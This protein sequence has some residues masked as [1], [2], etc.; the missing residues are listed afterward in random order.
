MA[1][2][3]R[4]YL[5][6]GGCVVLVGAMFV[7]GLLIQPSHTQDAT[8]GPVATGTGGSAAAAGA[9]AGGGAALDPKVPHVVY[10]ADFKTMPGE[11]WSE[12][13]PK[14]TP[15]GARPYW[16]DFYP[17]NSPA[18]TVG[19]LPPHK[20]VRLTYDMLL[21]KSWDGSSPTYGPSVMD[22]ALG[23]EDGRSL[24]H[25]T[26][27]NMGMYPRVNN[28]QSFP[29][30]YFSRPYPAFTLATEN[31]T[32][33]YMQSFTSQGGHP[34]DDPSSVYHMVMTFPHEAGEIVVKWKTTIRDGSYKGYGFMNMRV[35]TLPELKTWS[36]N[37]YKMFWTDLGRQTVEEA[38]QFYTAKW[39]LIAAGDG[40]VA[41][42]EK[43]LAENIDGVVP[44]PEGDPEADRGPAYQ[45]GIF[46]KTPTLAR[47]QRT[48]DVLEAIHTPAA[49]AF[50]EKI[51]AFEPR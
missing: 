32:L 33:G 25:A 8:V 13:T 3:A 28:E 20:L 43:H 45:K 27:C 40:A 30:N 37:Q 9:G 1:A 12:G 46:P 21:S 36:E 7:A 5:I 41:Y 42:M 24:M 35:E 49:L 17:N 38:Q 16:G 4:V 18:L 48:R 15:K 2:N 51:V 26:F 11:E 10:Q 29:D 34:N 6:S 50:K 44:N 22:M 14:Q 19:D 47:L 31:Q 39:N 23:G